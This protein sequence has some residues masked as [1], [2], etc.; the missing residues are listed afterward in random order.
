MLK[1]T[2]QT[3]QTQLTQSTQMDLQLVNLQLVNLQLPF[4]IV[5]NNDG[6]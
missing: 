4:D 5:M 3:L 2:Q 1:L 6:K